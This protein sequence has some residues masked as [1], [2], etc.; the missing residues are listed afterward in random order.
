MT[1]PVVHEIRPV[2]RTNGT[3]PIDG[4]HEAR[5][6]EHKLEPLSQRVRRPRQE[7]KRRAPQPSALALPGHTHPS[8]PLGPYSFTPAMQTRSPLARFA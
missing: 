1:T 2:V 4:S 7:E 8:C 3:P 5:E 6:R